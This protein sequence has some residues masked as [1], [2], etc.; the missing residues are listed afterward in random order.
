MR[1]TIEFP[2]ELLAAAKI[3]AATDGISLKE[4]FVAAVRQKLSPPSSRKVRRPPPTIG[5]ADGPPIPDLTREQTDEA[6]FG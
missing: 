1:T 4:F 6:L 3:Q 5:G 2:D